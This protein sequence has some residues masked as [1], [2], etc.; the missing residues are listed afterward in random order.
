MT[1]RDC[2]IDFDRLARELRQIGGRKGRLQ[3]DD[4]ETAAGWRALPRYRGPHGAALLLSDIDRLS[5]TIDAPDATLLRSYL[6]LGPDADLRAMK[7]YAGIGGPS[8]A[9]ADSAR[10]RVRVHL[11]PQLIAKLIYVSAQPDASD[12][13]PDSPWGL[14]YRY[15]RHDWSMDLREND[16]LRE[17]YVI[18][19]SIEA[20]LP[21][22]RVF[23]N[24]A[25]LFGAVLE[26]PSV[27]PGPTH[28]VLV[29]TL[30]VLSG[31]ADRCLHFVHLERPLPVRGRATITIRRT[32][33]HAGPPEPG[34]VIAISNPVD[35]VRLRVNVSRER[36]PEY[37]RVH[38]EST[39]PGATSAEPPKVIR[40]RSDAPMEYVISEPAVGHEYEIDW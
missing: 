30:P 31:D 35:S 2:D 34:F 4:L 19:T 13:T 12:A 9:H 20:V 8:E 18:T 5:R 37:R 33:R 32:T 1:Q 6:R 38:R 26:N 27:D 39:G 29:G 28:P 15:I 22:Q 11:L 40:R 21:N 17:H 25:E 23:V 3:A 14:G 36:V 7:R 10:Y 24:G 16:P